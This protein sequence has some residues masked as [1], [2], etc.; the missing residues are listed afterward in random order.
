[1]VKMR[2]TPSRKMTADLRGNCFQKEM[3]GLIEC[4]LL[5]RILT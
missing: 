3:V 1:V 5:Q 4:A 2:N